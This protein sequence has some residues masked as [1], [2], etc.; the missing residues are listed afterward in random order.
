MAF[1]KKKIKKFFRVTTVVTG[2]AFV[3]LS[4]CAKM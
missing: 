3:T 1:N 2:A 4:D